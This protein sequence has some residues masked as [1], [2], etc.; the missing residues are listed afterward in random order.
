VLIPA[1]GAWVSGHAQLM[2]DIVEDVCVK[3]SSPKPVSPP[4]AGCWTDHADRGVPESRWCL[5]QMAAI[6]AGRGS[7]LPLVMDAPGHGFV[8][9]RRGRLTR[10]AALRLGRGVPGPLQVTQPLNSLPLRHSPACCEGCGAKKRAGNRQACTA[11]ARP[12]CDQITALVIN[13]APDQ[14]R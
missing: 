9:E 10:C 5:D 11:V 14:R 13:P 8:M 3:R 1:P 7:R 12:A 2:L 6:C 4:G